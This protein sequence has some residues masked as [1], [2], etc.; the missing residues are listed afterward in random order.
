[1][2][3][4]AGE[5]MNKKSRELVLRLRVNIAL[6]LIIRIKRTNTSASLRLHI[7]CD[8]KFLEIDFSHD[9]KQVLNNKWWEIA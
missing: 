3:D 9:S 5:V 4:H 8:Q 7:D 2:V 1:M 6:K